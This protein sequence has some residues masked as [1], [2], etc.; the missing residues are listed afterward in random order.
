MEAQKANRS[1]WEH[2]KC[3]CE[4][5]RGVAFAEYLVVLTAVSLVGSAAVLALGIPLVQAFRFAQL[6]IALPFP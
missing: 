4:D 1:V 3:I 6:F 2:A 5:D